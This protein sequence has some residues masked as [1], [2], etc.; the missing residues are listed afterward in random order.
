[1]NLHLFFLC[2]VLYVGL[3]DAK[4]EKGSGQ[5]GNS[6]A[7]D[8]PSSSAQTS[9]RYLVSL[10]CLFS[11]TI[12]FSSRLPLLRRVIRVGSTVNQTMRVNTPATGRHRSS[13]GW[14]GTLTIRTQM[15]RAAMPI[16]TKMLL[17]R[18]GI[19]DT[20]LNR[21]LRKSRMEARFVV[22]FSGVFRIC[23]VPV[24]VQWWARCF[25]TSG[26]TNVRRLTPLGGQGW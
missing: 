14:N 24:I 13:I 16:R 21:R 7:S 9:R 19:E 8:K 12:L 4:N 25:I 11:F 17:W 3:T 26:S 2:V 1:M 6:W 10:F 23:T 5:E 20:L 15:V 22:S 18:A